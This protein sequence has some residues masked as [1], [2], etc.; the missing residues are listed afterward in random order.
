MCTAEYI[1]LFITSILVSSQGRRS[2]RFAKHLRDI[3][4]KFRE[5]FLGSTDDGDKTVLDPDWTVMQVE[6]FPWFKAWC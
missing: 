5:N 3:G 6:N 4:D 2:L 1:V